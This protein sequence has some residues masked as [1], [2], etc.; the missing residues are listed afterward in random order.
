MQPPTVREVIKRLESEGWK[1][2]RQ[3]GTSHRIFGKDGTII[4]IA[5]KPGEHLDR[6]TYGKIKR[7]AGW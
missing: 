3:N 7:L 2:I 4:P 6:G 1:L 5:G